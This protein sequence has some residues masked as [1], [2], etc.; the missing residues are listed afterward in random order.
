M[1]IT[2]VARIISLGSKHTHTHTQNI[3]TQMFCARMLLN[4][5]TAAKHPNPNTLRLNERVCSNSAFLTRSSPRQ[6]FPSLG[7]GY[8]MRSPRTWCFRSANAFLKVVTFRAQGFQ[9]CFWPHIMDQRGRFHRLRKKWR[10]R[11]Y[12]FLLS[13]SKHSPTY[14]AP[15]RRRRNTRLHLSVLHL[16]VLHLSVLH[17]S[18]FVPATIRSQ[19]YVSRL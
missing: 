12:S 5:T 19:W 9:K 17:L 18:V 4:N 15:Q 3:Q 6:T 16:S 7:A 13:P 1:W 8:T 14:P 10:E 11:I 2:D